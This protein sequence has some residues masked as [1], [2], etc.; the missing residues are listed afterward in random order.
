MNVINGMSSLPV[1]CV[2]NL[3]FGATFLDSQGSVCCIMRNGE[4][5]EKILVDLTH[6][7]VRF[8][9]QAELHSSVQLVKHTLRISNH[10]AS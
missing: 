8:P 1:A 9:S 4:T 10:E 5:T 6:N 3:D 7:V 2:K